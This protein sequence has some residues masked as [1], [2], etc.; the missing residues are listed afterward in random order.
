MYNVYY[1]KN[2]TTIKIVFFFKVLFKNYW[3]I[4]NMTHKHILL[5][6]IKK[7]TNNI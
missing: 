6:V 1:N 2:I 4:V 3:K 5:V 7:Y